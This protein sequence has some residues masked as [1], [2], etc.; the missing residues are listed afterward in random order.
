MRPVGVEVHKY[1]VTG[2][3]GELDLYIN[4]MYI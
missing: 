4:S 1:P 2:N 3:T